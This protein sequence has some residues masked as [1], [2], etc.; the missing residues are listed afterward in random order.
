MDAK[1]QDEEEK[2]YMTL[3]WEAGKEKFNKLIL[4]YQRQATSLG[5]LV[6]GLAL[7]LLVKN[8]RTALGDDMVTLPSLSISDECQECL[9][10]LC[11]EAPEVCIACIAV[12]VL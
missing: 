6:T 5:I 7:G 11:P 3:F 12:C 2:K 4:N 1:S 10:A 8:V 9:L